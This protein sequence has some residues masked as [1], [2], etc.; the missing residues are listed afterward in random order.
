M[1]GFARKSIPWLILL[2][3]AFPMYTAVKCMVALDLALS[4]YTSMAW[5]AI[6]I[7]F[8]SAI[9]HMTLVIALFL[10]NIILRIRDGDE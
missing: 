4:G 1:S 3:S 5:E 8:L 2:L 9:L 10:L 7:H 6:V